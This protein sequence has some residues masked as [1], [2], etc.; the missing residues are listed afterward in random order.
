[1]KSNPALD[2]RRKS[3]IWVDAFTRQFR[4]LDQLRVGWRFWYQLTDKIGNVF[5][6]GS[7]IRVD[8][9]A[10]ALSYSSSDKRQPLFE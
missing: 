2:Q 8:K 3:V 5:R 6:I 1:M 10:T 7:A 9:R 4:K